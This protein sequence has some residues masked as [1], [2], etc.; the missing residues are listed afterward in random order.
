[1][2]MVMDMFKKHINNRLKVIAMR[3]A[4]CLVFALLGLCMTSQVISKLSFFLHFS[5]FFYLLGRFL[6]F[7]FIK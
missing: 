1:M 2:I 3:F 4:V 5:F 6:Y 7:K